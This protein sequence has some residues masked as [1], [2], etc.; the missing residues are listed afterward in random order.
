MKNYPPWIMEVLKWNVLIS[1]VIVGKNS[2]KWQVA[3]HGYLKNHQ[4]YFEKLPQKLE[5]DPWKPEFSKNVK[6]LKFSMVQG[7]LNPNITFLGEKLFL[8][9]W[10]QKFT[11]DTYWPA[12]SEPLENLNN[13]DSF[14][15]KQLKLHISKIQICGE[16]MSKFHNT[17]L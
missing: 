17:S 9:A 15:S 8:V 7:P 5:K 12:K 3:C 2:L 4:S 6:S 16:T 13:F 11:S 1:I 10:K 14:Y